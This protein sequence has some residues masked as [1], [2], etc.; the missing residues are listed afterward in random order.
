MLL[1]LAYDYYTNKTG[2]F[3]ENETKKHEEKKPEEQ[4]KQTDNH[5]QKDNDK[6]KEKLIETTI[7]TKIQNRDLMKK[8]ELLQ[9]QVQKNKQITEDLRK[10]L[11]ESEINK[12]TAE[13]EKTKT[14]QYSYELNKK[15]KQ[16]KKYI[17]TK[18]QQDGGSKQSSKKC[19]ISIIFQKYYH[20]IIPVL[21][22]LICYKFKYINYIKD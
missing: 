18:K 9:S 21:I 2:G 20:I 15:Y 4:E 7:E 3:N 8:L 16:L 13:K 1:N 10:K 14:Q 12:K 6:E 11:I 5:K 22:L 19:G 17:N